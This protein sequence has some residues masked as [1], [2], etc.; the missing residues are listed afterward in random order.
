M[1]V[2][3][4]GSFAILLKWIL[5]GIAFLIGVIFIKKWLKRTQ[6]DDISKKLFDLYSNGLFILFIAWKGSLLLLDPI[7]VLKSP[8]SLL[9]FT[10]GDKGLSISIIITIV[11][12]IY[13]GRKITTQSVVVQSLL[14]FCL[15]VASAYNFLFLYFLEEQELLHLIL[16]SISSILLYFIFNWDRNLFLNKGG[17]YDK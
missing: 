5:L 8:L 11:Y 12:F 3:Q 7:L 14:I 13:K 17:S 6:E 9:Y 16:G 2:I 15:T 1:K 10:G 4:I